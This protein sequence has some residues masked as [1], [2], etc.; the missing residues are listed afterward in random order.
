MADR[1]FQIQRVCLGIVRPH[2]LCNALSFVLTGV[3]RDRVVAERGRVVALTPNFNFR[4]PERKW[5][6]IVNE[7]GVDIQV[8]SGNHAGEGHV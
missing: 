1:S 3:V 5:L 7:L 8:P 4:T 6:P 2:S